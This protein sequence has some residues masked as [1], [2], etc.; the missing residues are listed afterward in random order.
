M[1]KLI[2]LI[3][4]NILVYYFYNN[5]K[6]LLISLLIFMIYYNIKMTK[7]IEGNSECAEKYK[8]NFSKSLNSNVKNSREEKN[9]FY[10]IVKKLN[11]F[12]E[13][14]IDVKEPPV[15]QPCMGQF[16]AWSKCSRTCGGG[17]QSRRFKVI[18]EAGRGGIKCIY[19]NGEI[20]KKE[21]FDG[22]CNY[23]EECI[24]DMDCTTNYCNPITKT[25]GVEYECT[26]RTLYNCDFDECEA[27]GEDYHFDIERGCRK[28]RIE[29]IIE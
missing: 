20:D 3:L 14:Y 29:N 15:Q 19:D 28:Y 4:F 27:L 18:Q 10:R 1:N 22:L 6:Y 11:N 16:N 17:E 24:Y 25:C 26:K 7:T 2:L 9:L 23:D 13:R 12:L 5:N 21:C 8:Y